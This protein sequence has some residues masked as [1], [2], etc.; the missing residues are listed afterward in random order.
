MIAVLFPGCQY[1]HSQKI[2]HRD[3][4]LSNLFVNDQMQVKIGDFGLSA[5]IDRHDDRKE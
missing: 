1:I 3:L 5:Y 2:V 4:K